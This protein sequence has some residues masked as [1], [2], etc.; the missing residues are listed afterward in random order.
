MKKNFVYKMIVLIS[1]IA[2]GIGCYFNYRAEAS[3]A[4][5]AGMALVTSVFLQGFIEAARMIVS[6]TKFDWRYPVAG[7]GIA[8]LCSLICVLI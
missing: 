5:I 6:E 2:V 8:A 7:I 1:A 4:G 3:G